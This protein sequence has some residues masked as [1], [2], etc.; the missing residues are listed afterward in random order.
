MNNLHDMWILPFGP[1]KVLRTDQEGGLI[2]KEAKVSL[3]R[4]GITLDVRPK[5]TKAYL[6]EA[7]HKILR[8]T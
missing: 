4:H 1:M 7:H 5:G 8:D 2:S 3:S 6:V